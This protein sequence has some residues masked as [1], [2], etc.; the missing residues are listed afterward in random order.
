MRSEIRL[1][2][3]G[4]VAL[5]LAVG[6]ALETQTA[7]NGVQIGFLLVP[8]GFALALVLTALRHY[9]GQPAGPPEPSG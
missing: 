8:A 4:G 6:A 2:L 3:F 5:G 7:L 1:A 9:F